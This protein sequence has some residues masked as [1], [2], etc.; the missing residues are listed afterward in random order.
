MPE[1][2]K[3]IAIAHELFERNNVKRKYSGD[4]YIVH[5]I[6]VMC[7]LISHGIDDYDILCAAILHDTI[8]DCNLSHREV[9][10]LFKTIDENIMDLVFELTDISKPE[11]DNRAARKAIDCQHLSEASYDAM[12][13][14]CAD[15]I[16]NLSDIFEHDKDFARVYLDEAQNK[17]DV[18]FEKMCDE[19]IYKSLVKLHFELKDKMEK[20]LDEEFPEKLPGCLTLTP[21]GNITDTPLYTAT[22]KE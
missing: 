5:P 18:M 13:I 8:E 19:K 9:I 12:L 17:L 16:D 15:M 20:Y 14:K 6:R 22:N 10:D 1:I 2:E 21:I 7:I 11:E 3:I 4:S